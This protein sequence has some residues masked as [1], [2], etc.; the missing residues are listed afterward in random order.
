MALSLK[1]RFRIRRWGGRLLLLYLAI[2]AAA[3][4]ISL[5]GLYPAA[6]HR[7][8]YALRD[9][10]MDL[11]QPF[12]SCAAAHAAGFYNI[13]SGSKAY[14]EGQDRDGDGLACEPY[15]GGG[16]GTFVGAGRA[17]SGG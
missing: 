13:P 12:T 4:V 14:V 7:L 3:I 11:T 16:P 2:C 8:A 10:A 1:T 9:P 15:S 6:S 17:S 5:N